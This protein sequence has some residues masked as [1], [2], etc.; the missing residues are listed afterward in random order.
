MSGAAPDSAQDAAAQRVID[1]L[2]GADSGI[3]LDMIQSY[4]SYQVS[5][6][7]A[8]GIAATARTSIATMSVRV[9]ETLEEMI[10]ALWAFRVTYGRQP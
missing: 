1:T 9:L 8:T 10:F 2:F 6:P 7:A 5:S 3:T 4:L